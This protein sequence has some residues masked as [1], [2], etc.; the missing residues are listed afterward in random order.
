MRVRRIDSSGDWVFGHGLADYKTGHNAVAQN[1]V[2]R[3]KSFA[4]DWFLDM[5]AG[6]D[7]IGLMGQKGSQDKIVRE[8]ARVTLETSGVARIDAISNDYDPVKRTLST[9]LTTTDIYGE[10]FAQEIGVDL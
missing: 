1:I 3:V 2:T 4:R 10:T 7:W 6:I 9:S 8:V 5:K